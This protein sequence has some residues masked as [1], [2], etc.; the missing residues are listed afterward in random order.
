SP[1]PASTGMPASPAAGSPGLAS[2]TPL[3]GLGGRRVP[4]EALNAVICTETTGGPASPK[5]PVPADE[6][7]A[8]PD[9]ELAVV[10]EDGLAAPPWPPV[11]EAPEETLA[12]APVEPDPDPHAPIEKNG[13]SSAASRA[14]PSKAGR[15]VRFELFQSLED[16]MLAPFSGFQERA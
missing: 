15:L 16:V 9:D 10:P 8:G 13:P 3:A 7:A 1:V 14:A 2:T 11:P 5:P 6:L 12:L 4:W